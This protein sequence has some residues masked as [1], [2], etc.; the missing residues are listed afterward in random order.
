M[1]IQCIYVGILTK[2]GHRTSQCYCIYDCGLFQLIIILYHSPSGSNDN[3][4]TE[5]IIVTYNVIL[6]LVLTELYVPST[7]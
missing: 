4:Y 3:K 6:S 5:Y 7:G 2:L 1:S